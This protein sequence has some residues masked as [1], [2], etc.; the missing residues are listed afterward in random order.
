MSLQFT[1]DLS[2]ALIALEALQSSSDSADD[3]RLINSKESM[4]HLFCKLGLEN[5]M[6]KIHLISTPV[7]LVNILDD[8][9]HKTAIQADAIY[10]S[11]LFRILP[12]T[13]TLENQ[14]KQQLA[15]KSDIVLDPLLAFLTNGGFVYYG[16]DYNIVAIHALYF[17]SEFDSTT[18][19][20]FGESIEM[21]PR[22]VLELDQK[23]L[24]FPML[25]DSINTN[26][27]TSFTWICPNENVGLFENV[28][29]K[30][31]FACRSTIDSK[32]MFYPLKLASLHVP[33]SVLLQL[34]CRACFLEMSNWFDVYDNS[35][36]NGILDKS[37]AEEALSHFHNK[38]LS[39]LKVRLL[40]VFEW[41]MRIACGEVTKVLSDDDN[42]IFSDEGVLFMGLAAMLFANSAEPFHPSNLKGKYSEFEFLFCLQGVTPVALKPLNDGD[43]GSLEQQCLSE[44]NAQRVTELQGEYQQVIAYVL[45]SGKGEQRL[46]IEKI[47]GINGANL[48]KKFE[49]DYISKRNLLLNALMVKSMTPTDMAKLLPDGA[50]SWSTSSSCLATSDNPSCE[51][52]LQVSKMMWF[53]VIVKTP[54]AR[55]LAYSLGFSWF[56]ILSVVEKVARQYLHDFLR[57]LKCLPAN[58]R[59]VSQ[60]NINNVRRVVQ[61][62]LEHTPAAARDDNSDDQCEQLKFLNLYLALKHLA[63]STADEEFVAITRNWFKHQKSHIPVHEEVGNQIKSIVSRYFWTRQQTKK[64]SIQSFLEQTCRST[65]EMRFIQCGRGVRELRQ[66]QE[67]IPMHLTAT[68]VAERCMKQGIFSSTYKVYPYDP[69]EQRIK[70][71][72]SAVYCL[73]IVKPVVSELSATLKRLERE[74]GYMM[75]I[76]SPYVITLFHAELSPDVKAY[77]MMFKHTGGDAINTLL[78][79]GVVFT[80]DEIMDVALD[81]LTGLECIHELGAIHRDIGSKSIIRCICKEEGSERTRHIIYDAEY[82]IQIGKHN[83]KDE[84]LAFQYLSKIITGKIPI[85]PPKSSKSDLNNNTRVDQHEWQRQIAEADINSDSKTDGCEWD[86]NTERLL[87]PENMAPELWPEL[88]HTVK[89]KD[90]DFRVDIWAVGVL[91]FYLIVGKLPFETKCMTVD[92]KV[93]LDGI[94]E[95]KSIICNLREPTPDIHETM[96]GIADQ[97]S[98]DGNGLMRDTTN[99]RLSSLSL[100]FCTVVGKAMQKK[101][102][103]RYA[104][105]KEMKDAIR[106]SLDEYTIFISYRQYTEFQFA[107]ML[108]EELNN[109]KTPK[110]RIVSVFLDQLCLKEMKEWE[111]AFCDALFKSRI[112]MPIVTAGFTGKSCL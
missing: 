75:K 99:K 21:D 51:A 15:T 37:E 92:K 54:E 36:R 67:G 46:G 22:I 108:Y 72:F 98:M 5:H 43:A 12:A 77:T 14:M 60:G 89:A 42:V 9:H 95:L 63:P 97:Y 64:L 86:F 109:Q 39:L 85:P 69:N 96:Q 20:A 71:D 88:N 83:D 82:V 25:Q 35:P 8:A 80:T 2:R 68:F 17:G 57:S 47:L 34:R 23:A 73:K 76:S 26:D 93:S 16:K 66:L 84:D 91:I 24:W 79:N 13:C 1:M 65:S 107:T 112:Y 6:S 33:G 70:W 100:G 103:S 81:V 30:G 44:C 48:L 87:L 4:E 11:F 111:E 41:Y 105:V 53:S 40:S 10:F 94:Q 58:G 90:V 110:G 104:S 49:A 3:E 101:K 28:N 50:S 19:L 61:K 78:L 45:E 7:S 29:I 31:G 62:A 52:V 18:T 55:V 56:E 27:F 102:E 106:E 38:F 32:A 74:A 59:A